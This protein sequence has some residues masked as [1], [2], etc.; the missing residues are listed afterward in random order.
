MFDL[1]INFV[2]GKK[3]LGK[4]IDQCITRARLH[5]T[6]ERAGRHQGPWAIKYS[7]VGALTV[8]VAD[9]TVPAREV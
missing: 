7:T 9:M 8:A 2:V 6:A 4:I 3:Q 1:E 5:R